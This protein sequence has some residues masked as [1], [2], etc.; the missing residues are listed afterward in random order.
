MPGLPG[1]ATPAPLFGITVTAGNA[2]IRKFILPSV[3]SGQ[4]NYARPG[5]GEILVTLKSGPYPSVLSYLNAI[6]AAITAAT[7][8]APGDPTCAVIDE[9]NTVVAVIMADASIDTI[10]GMTLVNS[11]GV[12]IGATYNPATGVI[13]AAPAPPTY[14]SKVG[15]VA[16]L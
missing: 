16:G 14:P 5:A 11:P 1:A 3:E 10:E 7:G 6:T 9:T 4:I 12:S 13:T 15:V 2:C 8:K